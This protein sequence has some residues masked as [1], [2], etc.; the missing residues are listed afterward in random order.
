MEVHPEAEDTPAEESLTEEELT[1]AQTDS[2]PTVSL[3][4][5]NTSGALLIPTRP[6]ITRK[7]TGRQSHRYWI[8][9]AAYSRTSM[10]L[11]TTW[12]LYLCC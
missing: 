1:I 9:A 10:S 8:S 7:E 12:T 2:T 5:C 11:R 3:T 4:T 6:S